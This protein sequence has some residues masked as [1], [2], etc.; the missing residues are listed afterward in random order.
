LVVPRSIPTAL[1]ICVASE[2]FLATARR[3]SPGPD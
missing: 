2:F 1:D 3:P